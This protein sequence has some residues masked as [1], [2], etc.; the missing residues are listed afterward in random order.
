MCSIT[1]VC[2]QQHGN[3]G[4][5]NLL[6]GFYRQILTTRNKDDDDDDNNNNNNNNNNKKQQQQRFA[7]IGCP[8]QDNI[9]TSQI[10]L[11]FFA[12]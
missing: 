10:L 3:Y 5:I 12:Q 1:F 7:Y 4:C 9:S 8:A 11:T 2:V 6:V